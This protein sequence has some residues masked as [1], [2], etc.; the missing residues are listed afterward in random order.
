M[1]WYEELFATEDPARFDLYAESEASR[2]QVDFI[3]DKLALEPGA[4]VLDLCCG[5]GRHLIDLARRGYDVVGLDLSEYMLEGCRAAAAAEGIDV[6]LIHADM[7]QIGF[8]AEFD[9]V[10]NMFTSFGYLA[11]DNED[12]K[13]INAASLALKGGGSLLI[14]AMNRDWLMSVFKPTEWHTN[15]RGELILSEHDFDSITGRIN[16]R[17]ITIH[18]DGRRSE[19]PH[20]IRLYTFNE[21][22]KMLKQAGLIVQSTYGDFDSTPFN[23]GSRRMI[24]IARKE[25]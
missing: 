21:L 6:T 16:C 20:S 22:D 17:E 14:D 24:V 10:I 9:A 2:Q 13:V 18:S 3:I 1:A 7:R 23:R 19:R 5:Q 15:S 8:T 11:N 4:R 12:Q 25:T